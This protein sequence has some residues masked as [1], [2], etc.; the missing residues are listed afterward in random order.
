MLTA[1]ATVT[2]RIRLGTLVASPNFRHPLTLSREVTALDDV[3]LGRFDLGIGAGGRGWDATILGQEPWSPAERASRF[4]EFVELTDRL[5]VEREVTWTGRYYRCNE[6][7]SYPGCRQQPRVPFVVAATG[8]SAMKV[9]ARFGQGWVTTGPADGARN[10]APSE[11][12]RAVAVQRRL[13]E[14]ACEAVGR[15]PSTLR[16]YVLLGPVLEQGLS[17]V[18]EFSD[19]LGRYEESGVT[20]CVVHWPRAS[21]PFA[22]ERSNFERMV[23]SQVG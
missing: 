6:G 13:L 8:P 17:T 18:D 21:E 9:V 15:D 11:G 22:G 1:A 5:L 19:T 3:S 20:D 14:Q 4:A 2:S 23:L 12:A 7:R 16:H 10:V